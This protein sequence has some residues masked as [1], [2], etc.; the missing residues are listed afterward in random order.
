MP[1]TALIAGAGI[2][3]LSAAIALRRAGWEVRSSSAPR[4]RVNSLTAPDLFR[5]WIYRPGPSLQG[6][7]DVA[8]NGRHPPGR[9]T[10]GLNEIDGLRYRW[11]WTFAIMAALSQAAWIALLIGAKNASEKQLILLATLAL[12]C[13]VFGGVFLSCS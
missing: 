6:G 2:G 7:N 13:T 8:G 3:G 1:R 12:A 4:L 11:A 10:K 5:P 9:V